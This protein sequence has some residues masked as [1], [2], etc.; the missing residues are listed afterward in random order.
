MTIKEIYKKY[1]EDDCAYYE[2]GND[3]T[4][5]I[6]DKNESVYEIGI[7]TEYYTK[8]TFDISKTTIKVG[9]GCVD[10]TEETLLKECV[11]RLMNEIEMKD[12]RISNMDYALRDI[13]HTAEYFKEK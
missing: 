12:N 7:Q 9:E 2:L 10:T 5:T 8:V 13:I 11:I 3:I 4:I 6:Q 1:L